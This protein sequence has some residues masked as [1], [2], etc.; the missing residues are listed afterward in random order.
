MDVWEAVAKAWG[1]KHLERMWLLTVSS[2]TAYCLFA[3]FD[4][5]VAFAATLEILSTLFGRLDLLR[6]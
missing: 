5:L 1:W 2:L 3:I 6:L 4:L